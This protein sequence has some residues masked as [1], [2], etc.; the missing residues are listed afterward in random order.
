MPERGCPSGRRL[1]AGTSES[2]TR[3]G[4][5]RDTVERARSIRRPPFQRPPFW[6]AAL[7]IVVLIPNLAAATATIRTLLTSGFAFDW[8]NYVRATQHL[9]DG[10][11]YDF[12][13]PYT[14][15]WSP[16]AAWLLTFIVPL[17][18]A[19]WRAA[20]FVA[21]L[22][23]RDWRLIGLALISYPFWFDVETGNILVF[24]AVLAV[25]AYRGSRI[26]TGLFLLL[27]VLVP[28]PLMVPLTLWLLWGRANW[29]W[30]F[31]AAVAVHAAI[32]AATGWLGPWMATLVGSSSEVHASLNLAPSGA[33]GFWWVPVTLL[34]AAWFTVKGR[35]GLA[36]VAA[37][38]YWLPYYFL[39]L[40][41]E[42]VHPA[43]QATPV[44]S[45][46]LAPERARAWVARVRAWLTRAAPG[47]RHAH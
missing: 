25:C 16:V 1:L 8:T 10:T 37:S 35:L 41:L 30:P 14:F 5:V 12:A 24:V 44:T 42:F 46:P 7:A 27:F 38:P 26:A 19:A 2:A 21:L 28:R 32:L 9:F 45:P 31:V 4:P 33:I 40:L 22:F 47:G 15:R 11:L 23:L 3:A 29:R 20:H 6:L 36:S 17:G 13:G 34:L 39:M 43:P 18:L